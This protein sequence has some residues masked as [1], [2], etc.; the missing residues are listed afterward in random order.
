[1]RR[2]VITMAVALATALAGCRSAPVREPLPRDDRY[3]ERTAPIQRVPAAPDDAVADAAAAKAAAAPLSMRERG[4]VQPGTGQFI[5]RNAAAR[6]TPPPAAGGDVTFNWE[7]VPLQEVVKSILGDLMQENY[8]IAPGVQ[9]MVT[10]STSRPINASQALGVLE[11]LLS[12]NN[13]AL[14]YKDGRYTVLPVAQALPGNLRPRVGPASLARGYEVRVVPLQF[15]G[16][17]EME[18]LLKPYAKPGAVISADN[19]RSMIVIAG[20]ADELQS[21]MDTI[22]IFDVDWLSGMSVGIYPLERVDAKEIVPELEKIFG[23]GGATPM[24]GMFRFMPIDRMNAVLVITPQPRYLEEAE[25][26]LERLDRGGSEGGS[27]LFVYYVKN[28][29]AKDLATNLTEVFTGRKSS[30]GARETAPIGAV[31]PGVESVEISSIN[32]TPA[33]TDPNAQPV[34]Q[35]DQVVAPAQPGVNSGDGIAVVESDDIKITAIEE[36]NALMIRATSA[37]YNAI[38]RAIE[39]LDTVPLQ[40]VIEAKILQVDLT[41]NLSFGVRWFFENAYSSD[42]S[43]D[44]RVNNRRFGQE[45]EAGNRWNSFA[46]QVTASGLNWTFL[47]TSAEAVVSAVQD[48]GKVEVLA[49]PSLLVLNNKEANINVGTQI[50]VVST[51]FSGSTTGSVDGNVNPGIN[52]SY[53][54]FRDTGI[55]LSVTPRVNPG[56]LV[57]LEIKQEKSTPGAASAAVAGNVPVNKSTVETEVAIQSGQ[58][59]L[60]GG[61]IQ[62]ETTYGEGG[63]PFLHKIPV[64]GKLFGDT[65]KSST[66]K[67]LLVLI[68]PTVISNSDD[69]EV[70]TDEYKERFRNLQPL[71]QREQLE[72]TVL[73]PSQ[74]DGSA[75]T[76]ADPIDPEEREEPELE[77]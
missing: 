54:Q 50:P 15:I 74:R 22:E 76:Q 62:D 18:K 27:Q 35:P 8:V 2:P 3:E 33:N 59:V 30:G 24:A 10:F 63:V 42:A 52:Q 66:R 44:Y 20:N 31:I 6:N 43:A 36:S 57:F 60:L 56:G 1:M 67:E 65:T 40:V 7:N 72:R 5:N 13:A 21:Y 34:A 25:R 55:I 14:V 75:P 11:M 32:N 19:A 49:A 16:A 37:Q 77:E 53:V 12:W 45:N 39:R 46:G 41:G 28:V 9:G 71:I 51:F 70:I 38:E 64:V 29:K 48:E 58:T 68:T 17:A 47:N 4:E 69:A 26:W 73:L 23:E 61:L